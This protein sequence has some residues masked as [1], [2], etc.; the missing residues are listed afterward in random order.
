MKRVLFFLLVFVLAFGAACGGDDDDADTGVEEGET[1]TVVTEPADDEETVE[2]TEV[3]GDETPE[4]DMTG[5]PEDDIVETPDVTPDVDMTGTPEDDETPAADL[6]GTPE[7]D[8]TPAMDMTETPETDMT[9]TPEADVTGTVEDEETPEVDLTGTPEADETPA[10]DMTE[11]P[12]ADGTPA[13]GEGTEFAVGEPAEVGDWTITVESVST[14]EGNQF[15]EP[16][17]GNQ[18]LGVEL[19]V[20]NAGSDPVRVLRMLSQIQ[21][22]TEDGETYD[23]SLTATTVAATEGQA[24]PQAQIEPGEEVTGMV[25]FEVPEDATQLTLVIEPDDG[26]TDDQVRIDLEQ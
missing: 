7:E 6:T 16:E 9:G 3:E 19:T 26:T 14:I 22:E 25:G 10:T 17:A 12:E 11:T 5:T 8:E 2:V 1:E 13:V 20:E 18:F 23:V 15:I 4:A 21:I 24:L